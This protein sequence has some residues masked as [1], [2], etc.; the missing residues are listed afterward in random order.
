MTV[1]KDWRKS[2]ESAWRARR[3]AKA[4]V[5]FLSRRNWQAFH[6]GTF[7][8]LA[9]ELASF[10][11]GNVLPA[12]LGRVLPKKFV[13]LPCG[14]ALALDSR[15]GVVGVGTPSGGSRLTQSRSDILHLGYAVT[16]LGRVVETIEDRLLAEGHQGTERVGALWRDLDD[17]LQTVEGI[18][19]REVG[20]MSDIPDKEPDCDGDTV[21]P[22][23]RPEGEYPDKDGNIV[24]EPEPLG[25]GGTEP[26][27]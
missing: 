2:F 24:N 3:D 21:C 6:T 22:E 5:D 25:Q 10:S 27:E 12:G 26:T 7:S 19:V 9:Q 20:A 11:H 18:L 15:G 23:V 8:S 16:A 4:L 17:I 13:V 1:D 14:H